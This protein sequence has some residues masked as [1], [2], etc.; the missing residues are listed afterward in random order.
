MIKVFSDSQKIRF[1]K[2]VDTELKT[3][4][5]YDVENGLIIK[6]D[7]GTFIIKYEFNLR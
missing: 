7:Q 2:F 1:T 5:S 3:S 4:K 6:G